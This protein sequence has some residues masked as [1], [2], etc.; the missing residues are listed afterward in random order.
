MKNERTIKVRLMKVKD[1]MLAEV[2]QERRAQTEAAFEDF[3]HKH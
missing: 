1:M 3:S 2:I